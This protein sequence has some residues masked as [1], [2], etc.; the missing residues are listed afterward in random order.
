MTGS[1]LQTHEKDLR[2]L[3][4]QFGELQRE[5]TRKYEERPLQVSK[6]TEQFSEL[7]QQVQSNKV[8]VSQ[9]IQNMIDMLSHNTDRGKSV[10]SVAGKHSSIPPFPISS[11]HVNDILSTPPPFTHISIPPT[12]FQFGNVLHPPVSIPVHTT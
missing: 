5:L 4:T 8:D 12:T 10:H 2:Q 6:L 1:S 7:T 9:K 11:P 3:E